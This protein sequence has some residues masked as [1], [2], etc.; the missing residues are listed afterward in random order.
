VKS[1]AEKVPLEPK[2]PPVVSKGAGISLPDF[3]RDSYTLLGTLRFMEGNTKRPILRDTG[4]DIWNPKCTSRSS[5]DGDVRSVDRAWDHL[6]VA[7]ATVSEGGQPILVRRRD[8]GPLD[9][10]DS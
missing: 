5:L 7:Q 10:T 8:H 9:C 1:D 4:T 3:F 6:G 2:I